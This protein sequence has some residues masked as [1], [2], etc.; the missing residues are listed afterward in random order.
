MIMIGHGAQNGL[1]TILSMSKVF[2]GKA[3]VHLIPLAFFG[4][5]CR[6][7]R[8][9]TRKAQPGR[10]SESPRWSHWRQYYRITVPSPG[11]LRASDHDA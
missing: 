2:I 4:D 3:S 5:S 1:K 11:Q 8:I 7:F 6:M 10:G 9:V